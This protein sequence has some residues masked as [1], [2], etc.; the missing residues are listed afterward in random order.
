MI[1]GN[2]NGLRQVILN[3]VLNAVEA[4]GD[5]GGRV[6]IST[7]VIAITREELR[8]AFGNAELAP[9]D[10]VELAVRDDGCGMDPV[11][12]ARVFE[13]FFST[14]FSGRGL[15]MA[16]VLGI[17]QAHEG[18]ICVES[19]VGQGTCMRAL[20][21]PSARGPAAVSKVEVVETSSRSGTVLVVDD[22][23]GIRELAGEVLARAGF[24]VLKASGGREALERV[25]EVGAD[26]VDVVL[27]DLA[28]PDMSGEQ[29]FLR[30]RELRGD[31]PVI[32]VTGYDA[33]HIAENFAA[34]GIDA[35][36]R[37]PWEPEDL[38]I[39]VRKLLH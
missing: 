23:D 20:F 29:A 25:R 12:V 31:L 4:Q 10:V 35:L 15:G 39:T 17:V 6:V 36:L 34:R 24:R 28:M 33:A 37:K 9:G 26:G 3:L 1:E 5:A 38:V 22:D 18:A 8:D 32:L 2:A 13:P 16:A 14:K 7:A 19:A 11:T 27:L 21:P 30:L